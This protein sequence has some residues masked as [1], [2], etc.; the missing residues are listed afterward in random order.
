MYCAA[1]CFVY[2]LVLTL[3]TA[4]DSLFIFLIFIIIIL[5]L[6]TILSHPKLR[7]DQ[8]VL[9]ATAHLNLH[10]LAAQA[11]E[12]SLVVALLQFVP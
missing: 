9:D 12:S 6:N 4:F 7:S 3:S 8:N 1:L 10:V 11:L 2:S 5:L